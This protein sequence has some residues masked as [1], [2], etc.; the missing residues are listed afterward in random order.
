M[1]RGNRCVSL[2]RRAGTF[3]AALL[4]ASAPF[5]VAAQ[6]FSFGV[7]GDVP[8][9]DYER[10][11]LPRL[12][13]ETANEPLAFLLHVGDMKS[14]SS[15]CSDDLYLDRQRLLDAS[16][17]PLIFLPGD[18]E[19]TDCDRLLCG[20]YDPEERLA[21]LRAIFYPDDQSLGRRR[22]T[23]LRQS[24]QPAFSAY[25]ENVRL[26]LG[27]V[28]L[29]GLNVP[30]SHNN[31]GP[32]S[33]PSR[34]YQARAEANAAWI[35]ET[36]ALARREG[37]KGVV[38]AFQANPLFETQGGRGYRGLISQIAQEAADFPGQILVIHGDTHL[39]RIDQPLRNLA[40]GRP[41]ENVTRLE[42][43]GSPFMGWVKIVV[44]ENDPRLFLIQPRPYAPRQ[45]WH[46]G[47]HP[48]RSLFQS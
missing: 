19:W 29:A 16:P 35:A 3:L 20:G 32:G 48:R 42:T 33:T 43:M 12:L 13:A 5:P 10:E 28:L 38:L 45:P 47:R 25:R 23:L 8:Y 40:Q 9:S 44:D 46:Q 21:R 39:L 31:F 4:I 30:G 34:E 7:L 37:Q 24:H 14:G 1:S 11:H 6:T 17:H 2:A 15:H 22:M 27:P 18:N 41:M 26:R 36:F